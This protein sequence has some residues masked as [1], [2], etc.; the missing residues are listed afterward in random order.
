MEK[1]KIYFVHGW[2]DN[3]KEVAWVPSLRNQCKDED[4]DFMAFK[5]PNS[6]E[7]KIDEWVGFLKENI[8]VLDENI[9]FVGHSIGC[10]AILRYLSELNGNK[11]IGGCVFVAGWFN[12]LDTAYEEEEEREIA[13]SWIETPIDFE[14][15]KNHTTNFLSIF[16]DD[17]ECVPISDSELFKNKFGSKIITK[18]S[19]GHFDETEKIIEIMDFVK[20]E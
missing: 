7:P 8:A 14:K 6:E 10:Q 2:G 4:I 11:K 5:M 16:S 1:K 13:K 12:L 20:S 18:K 15:I 3:S 17:D 19:E 9:F